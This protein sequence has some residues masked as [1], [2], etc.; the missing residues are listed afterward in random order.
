MSHYYYSERITIIS[1]LILL[2]LKKYGRTRGHEVVLL[3]DQCRLDIRKYSF[4][5]KTINEYKKFGK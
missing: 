1:I 2:S 3:K 4:L 5:Q